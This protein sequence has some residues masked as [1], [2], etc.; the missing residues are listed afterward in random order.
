MYLE[1]LLYKLKQQTIAQGKSFNEVVTTIKET[2]RKLPR[3][4]LDTFSFVKKDDVRLL[5]KLKKN[6]SIVINKPDKGNGSVIM[7]R[8][9]Y[10]QKMND[11][12]S[13]TTK[14]R[15]C[16]DDENIYKNNLRME[17]KVN[18]Q[19]RRLKESGFITEE[20]YKGLHVSGSSPSVLYG[21]PKIHKEGTPLRPILAAFKTAS[22]KLAKF[23]IPFIQ[24]LSQN[25]YTL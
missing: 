9:D 20:E 5:S 17:D 15:K 23:I 13:D 12:L 14:F 6:N 2:T 21:L 1:Q 4:S 11:I 7:N 22:Y 8:D 24:P 3:H 16:D 18:H 10:L 25:E 19:L